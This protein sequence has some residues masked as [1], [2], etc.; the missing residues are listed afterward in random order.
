M[1]IIAIAGAS[2][3]GKTTLAQELAVELADL[4]A[5]VIALDS[6]YHESSHIPEAERAQRNYD[7]PDSLESD[8]LIKH[9]QQLIRG[10]AIQLPIYDFAT[11]NRSGYSP[12][13]SAAEVIILEGIFALYWPEIRELCAHR[14]FVD[15]S[16][17]TCFS[18]RFKRDKCE[19][20]RSADSI[21]AQWKTTVEP[22][23]REYALP[24]KQYA[25]RLVDGEQVFTGVIKELVEEIRNDMRKRG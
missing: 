15:T 17:D 18:R 25:S 3:S 19:R 8:L 24:T 14:L 5:T 12:L 4:G 11:H 20:G 23:Y 13:T 22:M 1:Q 2:G 10:E 21:T 7:H 9:I 6:Y 16:S